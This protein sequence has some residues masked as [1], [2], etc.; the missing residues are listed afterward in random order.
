MLMRK[1]T[2]RT[3]LLAL[4]IA[5]CFIL[6]ILFIGH[7]SNGTIPGNS[8]LQARYT[9][10][11]ATHLDFMSEWD[12]P[13]YLHIAKYG[14][15]DNS[16]TAFFPLYPLLIRLAMFVLSS[17]LISG[18]LVSWA[19]LTGAIYFYLKIVGELINKD[20]ND[21]I[22]G[23]MLF[24]FFPTG[25][26]LAATY[27]EALFA[28]LLL[29]SFYCALKNRLLWSAILSALATAAHPEGIFIIPLIML[30]LWENK[31]SLIKIVGVGLSGLVGILSYIVYLWLVKGKPLDF[32]H[33][34]R[35]NHWLSS[36]YLSTIASSI[37]AIDVLVFVLAVAAVF[38]W[39]KR[40][41]ALSVY[42]LLFVLLPFVGGNFAGYSRYLLMDFPLPL[43]LLSLFRRSRLA[44][45]VVLTIS[46][47]LWT[48][49]VIHYAAGYI[50]G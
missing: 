42:S 17:P 32:V 28:F 8:D 50:G 43:M 23:V 19:C 36:H 30:V 48:F 7:Y 6:L 34:Q 1:V 31:H 24:L 10:E 20:I 11:P 27:T 39:W 33:A 26:F 3:G 35:G 40:H 21:K 46:T 18:L 4:A 49:Y 15:T 5:V 44:F 29:G 37:T 41:V 16:L 14:Y 45:P 25:V 12:G 13:H 22:L 2:A 38:Y 47:V 9:L